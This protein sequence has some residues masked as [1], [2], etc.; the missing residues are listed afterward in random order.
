M[1]L[2]LEKQLTFVSSPLIP[3]YWGAVFW[4]T[5]KLTDGRSQYGAY[6][7]NRVNVV[8]HMVCVPLILFSA[9]E[10]VSCCSSFASYEHLLCVC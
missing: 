8:I 10:M 4:N 7:H 3:Q 1:S 6:H 5:P 9:F 2:D